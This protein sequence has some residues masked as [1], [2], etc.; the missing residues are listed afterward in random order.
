MAGRSAGTT[1]AEATTEAT[2]VEEQVAAADKAEDR[3]ERQAQRKADALKNYPEDAD[4]PSQVNTKDGT[5][6]SVERLIEDA[7][8]MLGVPRHVA[9]GAFHLEPDNYHTIDEAK[10]IVEAWKTGHV[11]TRGEGD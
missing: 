7:P 5:A 4:P 3:R 9:T 1:E 11:V 6:Y 2:E 8:T 10:K